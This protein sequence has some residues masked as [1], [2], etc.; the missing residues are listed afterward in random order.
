VA[1]TLGVGPAGGV[2]SG[3][4]IAVTLN[5]CTSGR[6]L[7]ALIIWTHAT[8]TI[9]SVTCTSESNMTLIGSLQHQLIN[10]AEYSLQIAYLS[11]ITAS[12]NK[13]VTATFTASSAASTMAITEFI[14][15]DTSAFYDTGSDAGADSNT[16]SVTTSVANCLV[17]GMVA[18]DAGSD[19][20][21]GTGYTA[22]TAL[23]NAYW[24]EEGQYDLDAGAA[25]AK[26]FDFDAGGVIKAAAFKP[27]G[28]AAAGAGPLIRGG[29]LTKGA[30]IRGGRLVA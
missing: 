17:I 6:S 25:G 12:G 30:T 13:T 27:S 9:S 14:G 21:P 4:T 22:I 8:A 10:G 26:T 29:S 24:W 5:G 2:T 23:G 20:T 1:I 16:V 11:N 3:T 15:G 7:V 28:G 18:S 19:P